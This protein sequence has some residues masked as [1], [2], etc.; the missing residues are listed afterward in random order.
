MEMI[1][2]VF[3]F[4]VFALAVYGAFLDHRRKIIISRIEAEAESNE[5]VEN[6][7]QRLKENENGLE[8]IYERTEKPE[9]ETFTD[10]QK[11]DILYMIDQRIINY[12]LQLKKIINNLEKNTLSRK[13][14][15]FPPPPDS[16]FRKP[17]ESSPRK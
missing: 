2:A 13:P 9:S 16:F 15:P 5:I 12:D 6:V 10:K 11:E 1:I 4:C 7:L 14:I 8:D 17:S 3:I